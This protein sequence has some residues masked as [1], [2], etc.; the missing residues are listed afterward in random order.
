MKFAFSNCC[1]KL[2]NDQRSHMDS[3]HV[4]IFPTIVMYSKRMLTLQKLKRTLLNQCNLCFRLTLHKILLMNLFFFWMKYT[5]AHQNQLYT[6]VEFKIEIIQYTG[7]TTSHM[8][9]KFNGLCKRVYTHTVRERE[10]FCHFDTWLINQFESVIKLKK[11]DLPKQN[12][13]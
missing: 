4:K 13:Y 2:W 11:N 1:Y 10:R 5:H 12:N 9:W 6:C 8:I 3:A 7:F